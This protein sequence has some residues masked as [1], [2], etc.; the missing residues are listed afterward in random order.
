[1][2]YVPFQLFYR[3]NQYYVNGEAGYYRYNY[4]F[5]GIGESAKASELYGVNFPRIRVN[6]F[7]QL[8][9]LGQTGRLYAGIRYQFENYQITETTVGGL[10]ANGTINGST[11]SQLSGAGLGLFFDSRDNVLA[12]STGHIVDLTYLT[13]QRVLGSSVT[14]TRWIADVASY[15]KLSHR[16]TIALN[17]FVSF[18]SGN[19][20]F[21]GLSLLGGTKKGRGFY[22]GRFRDDHLA[23]LQAEL[24]TAIWGRLGAVAFGSVGMLGNQSTGF[25]NHT[26]KATLGAGLRFRI[27]KDKLNLRL[28]Y[29]LGFPQTGFGSSG[30][31]VTVGEAF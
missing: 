23:L 25:R 19:A 31:Y 21:N 11:G 10:L 28:D 4:Y 14:F 17:Y 15:Y 16:T 2:F 27:N 3:N 9:D 30:L 26:P 8:L 22:E 24:R 29:G 7:R 5:F 20:P 13:H 1:L 6:A 12:P 18:T